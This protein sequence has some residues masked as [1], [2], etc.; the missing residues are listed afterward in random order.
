VPN[1]K[2]LFEEQV[3]WTASQDLIALRWLNPEVRDFP[4][5]HFYSITH[6]RQF[7]IGIVV[8]HVIQVWDIRSG[9][10]VESSSLGSLL[11]SWSPPSAETS[12]PLQS[13]DDFGQSLRTYKDKVFV[14]VSQNFLLE[15]KS[16]ELHT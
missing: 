13:G 8:S 15:I 9:T 2:V 16:D 12:K 10:L 6:S 14:L 4:P 3:R 5:S 11:A 1:G 7:V